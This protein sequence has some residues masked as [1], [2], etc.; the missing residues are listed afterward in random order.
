MPVNR[1]GP[2]VTNGRAQTANNLRS[3]AVPA[4]LRFW[5]QVGIHGLWDTGNMPVQGATGSVSAR[6]P[7]PL[8][9]V[10][11]LRGQNVQNGR[12]ATLLRQ[13]NHINPQM[14]AATETRG[15]S[16]LH[17]PHVPHAGPQDWVDASGGGM[18]SSR[19]FRWN[20]ANY[21]SWH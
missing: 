4:S 15:G 2:R 6:N 20:M 19:H 9:C 12:S 1:E 3:T 7:L 14:T 16:M 8:L 10:L 17:A 18:T 5:I 11:W 21:G 13:L